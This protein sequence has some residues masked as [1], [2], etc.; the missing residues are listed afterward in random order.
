MMEKM[1]NSKKEK[2][3]T[4]IELIVVIAIL[5]ILMAILIPNFTGF[6]E[7]ARRAQVLTDA[8]QIGTAVQ[9]MVAEGRIGA[10][11]NAAAL[12]GTDPVITM[13]GVLPGRITSLA[14]ETDGGFTLVMTPTGSTTAYTATRAD[15]TVS[16]TVSP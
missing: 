14:Y 6:Q 10:N 4:L 16:I 8:K 11:V 12:D 3:F 7:R 15:Q 5:G 9:T 2:G 13:S 1:R